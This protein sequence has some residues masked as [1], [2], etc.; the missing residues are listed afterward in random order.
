MQLPKDYGPAPLP[1][2]TLAAAAVDSG[3]PHI[4]LCTT[5]ARNASRVHAPQAMLSLIWAKRWL[6]VMW[7]K[8]SEGTLLDEA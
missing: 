1:S 7:Q 6:I 3:D 4:I 2:H 5:D 8:G